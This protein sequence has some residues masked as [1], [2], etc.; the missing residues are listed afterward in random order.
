[1]QLKSFVRDNNGGIHKPGELIELISS[2]KRSTFDDR[3]L[4][5][6]KFNDNSRG[7]VFEEEVND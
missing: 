6:V 2:S 3:V 5:N 4:L 1:M 7:A